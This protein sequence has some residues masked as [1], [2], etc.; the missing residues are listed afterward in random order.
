MEDNGGCNEKIDVMSDRGRG[1]GVRFGTNVNAGGELDVGCSLVSKCC[2]L[3]QNILDI[4]S[5]SPS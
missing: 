5:C 4:I 2:G 1:G 3:T